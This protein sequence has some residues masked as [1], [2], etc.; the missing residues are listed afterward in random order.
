MFTQIGAC[1]TDI[2]Q[3]GSNVGRAQTEFD[4]LRGEFGTRKG[5]IGVARESGAKLGSRV[6]RNFSRNRAS[7]DTI[8][9]SPP[10]IL[11]LFLYAL[12]Q[13]QHKF[14]LGST[15]ALQRDCTTVV[16]RWYY[17]G[18]WYYTGTGTT[19]LLSWYYTDVAPFSKRVVRVEDQY[20]T[21]AASV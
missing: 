20:G 5:S 18:T 4:P 9:K 6:V 2:G 19:R 11:A 17:A 14:N 1:S 8:W 21:R 15:L 16:L 12:A 7:R 13:V 3:A 10:I